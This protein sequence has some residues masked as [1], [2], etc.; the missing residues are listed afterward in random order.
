M[1]VVYLAENKLMGRKEV[2]KVIGHD[3][4][5]RAGV[6]DRFLREIRSAAQLHHTNIVTAYSAFRVGEDIVFAMEFVEGQ[7]LAAYVAS[8]GPLPVAHACNLSYQAALGLQY[9]H[10]QG[11]V[12]RDIKPSNLIVARQ[13]RRA[14]VKLLDFGLAGARGERPDD[15]RSSG[16]NR[17][18]GTPDFIAPE[19]SLI[20]HDADIR[21]DIYSLGCTLYFLLAGAPPFEAT[22][23]YEV[24]QAHHSMEAKPLNLVRRDVPWELAAV[25]AKMMAKD[26]KRR[27]Q[28]PLDAARAL[29]P[30]FQSSGSGG[31]AA[32]HEAAPAP[33]VETGPR[34]IATPPCPTGP[35]NTK[36][37][38][39]AIA[40][41]SPV[42]EA[43]SKKVNPSARPQQMPW[44]PDTSPGSGSGRL[45]PV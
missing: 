8:K 43:Q 15:E 44:S 37:A 28:T 23:V 6:R 34:P 24:L 25:V 27:Y 2:L 45:P 11:V 30:F 18:L 17:L 19:Q 40:E 14:L 12:H 32:A 41:L 36:A 9:A 22:S 38:P 1:A 35:A 33:A 21:A 39:P 13:G 5:D 7:D 42:S 26:R 16:R 31:A 10:E 3:L 20:E 4:M 29:M